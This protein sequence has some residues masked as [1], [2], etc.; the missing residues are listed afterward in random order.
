M[1]VINWYVN[2]VWRIKHDV[3]GLMVKKISLLL[4]LLSN[5]R[6]DS[7]ILPFLLHYLNKTCHE[8]PKFSVFKNSVETY[9]FTLWIHRFYV[10]TL[11]NI[12]LTCSLLYFNYFYLTEFIELLYKLNRNFSIKVHKVWMLTYLIS[13]IYIWN[14]LNQIIV[15]FHK[16]HSKF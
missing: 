5:S 8:S 12:V 14:I 13:T 1:L 15:N 10:F 2:N 16:K 4:S 3:G 7:P 9:V 6:V 11:Q